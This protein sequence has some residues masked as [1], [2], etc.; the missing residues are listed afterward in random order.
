MQK[1]S[2]IL[3]VVIIAVTAIIGVAVY[4]AQGLSSVENQEKNENDSM[5][6]NEASMMMDDEESKNE[7]AMMEGDEETNDDAM[8]NDN[9]S[10]DTE[11]MENVNTMNNEEDS[12]LSSDAAVSVKGEYTDY[13]ATRVADA[14]RSGKAI[15]FFHAPWCPTCSAL[16]KDIRANSANIPDNVV[17]FKTD[18]DTQRELKKKYGVTYQHTL[19]QV[20]E[21]GNQIT[22]WS[23]GN[24]LASLISKVQ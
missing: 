24:T 18:Y 23:G 4:A 21:N 8:M 19:V 15:L 14:A 20:D 6:Q 13:D 22:K 11:M 9:A 16:D 12:S 2:L 3:S 17:I 1:K 7:D 10:S 5:M